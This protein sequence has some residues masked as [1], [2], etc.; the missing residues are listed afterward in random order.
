MNRMWKTMI[1]I[2][3]GAILV[4]CGQPVTEAPQAEAAAEETGPDPTVVDAEHY[5]VEFENDQ[6]RVL[7]INYGPGEASVMHFHP[8]SVAVFL[9]DHHISF[10]RPDGSSEEVQMGAGEHIYSPAEQHLPT[11]L[12]DGPLELILVELKSPGAATSGESGPDSTVV[13]QDHY[14]VE[15]ENDQVRVLRINYG[16]GEASVMHYHPESVAVFLADHHVSFEKPDGSTEE[17]QIGAG[18]H[19]YAPAEQHLPTNVGEEPL[20]LILVE[21]KGS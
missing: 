16:P 7:R 19:S 9:T 21:L 6:V 12:G 2:T 3:I 14:K 8:D 20:E 11:N 10:E 15:F 4:S 17:A 1:L 13:D 18:V 5:K